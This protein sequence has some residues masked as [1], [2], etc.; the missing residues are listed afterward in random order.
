MSNRVRIVAIKN[1]FHKA[2]YYIAPKMDPI[3]K[4][5]ITGQ[6]HLS[7]EE[8]EALP[9][10]ID[11]D[12]SLP[13]NHLQMFDLE[14]ETDKIIF[15]FIKLDKAIAK[16]KKDVNPEVHR[17]YIEDKEEEAKEKISKTSKL[18]KALKFVDGLGLEELIDLGRVL[19]IGGAKSSNLE[20][21][22]AIEDLCVTKPQQIINV[23]DDPDRKYKMFLS[24]LVDGHILV[25]IDGGTY[26]YGDEVIGVNEQYAIEYLRNK[27]NNPVVTQWAKLLKERNIGG[28][29]K[30]EGDVI[31]VTKKPSPK[32]K[33]QTS[34]K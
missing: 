9:F 18:K 7:K 5:Y 22:S 12:T 26:K 29:D 30:Y 17:F 8:R 19:G 33:A 4:Q 11:E 10:K 20:I 2:P 25:K 13:V 31:A 24:K 3:K 14:N 23:F 34:S 27:E 21:Q 32:P 6:E 15:D 16:S 28:V 1:D